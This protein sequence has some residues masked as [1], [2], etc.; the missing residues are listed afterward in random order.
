M[1]VAEITGLDK[2]SN[3]TL[4]TKTAIACR[5]DPNGKKI[6]DGN[7]Q[8]IDQKD[9]ILTHTEIGTDYMVWPPGADTTTTDEAHR[10]SEVNDTANLD[11]SDTLYEV[12]L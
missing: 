4:G 2:D 9:R 5:Y 7:G 10:P 11:G 6:R 8:V 1:T 3:E 12:V